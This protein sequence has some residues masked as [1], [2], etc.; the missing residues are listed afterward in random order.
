MHNHYRDLL[1]F[2]VKG[3]L[4]PEECAR[5]GRHLD[6]CAT[7]RE[8]VRQWR[9]VAAAVN[10]DAATWIP[11]L[12]PPPLKLPDENSQPHFS[13]DG[14]RHAGEQHNRSQAVERWPMLVKTVTQSRS[15]V[16]SW[17]RFT[18]LVAAVLFAVMLGGVIL[19]LV[20]ILFSVEGR[21]QPAGPPNHNKVITP[22]LIP[23]P[24]P[25]L[26]PTPMPPLPIG[27]DSVD[28]LTQSAVLGQ[29]YSTDV[30]W[31]PDGKTL[32]LGTSMDVLLYDTPRLTSQP[33]PL[34]ISIGEVTSVAFS[35]DGTQLAIGG[36]LGTALWD[37]V[38]GQ[39]R[40]LQR[41]DG[42]VLEVAFSPDGTRLA[43][44]REDGMARIWNTTTGQM[45]NGFGRGVLSIAF[46]PDGTTLAAGSDDETVQFWD[47]RT[48][49]QLNTFR[50]HTSEVLSV[51][52]SPDGTRLASGGDD[53]TVRLWDVD[54]GEMLAVLEGHT[55]D[56]AIVAF[57]PDGQILAS[58]SYDNSVRL[59]DVAAGE[60][61]ATLEGH[62]GD[63]RSLAFSPDGTI[64]VSTSSW[65][66]NTV[67][68]WDVASGEPLSVLDGCARGAHRGEVGEVAFSPD[69][70]RLALSCGDAGAAVWEVST[71]QSQPVLWQGNGGPVNSLALSPDGTMLAVGRGDGRTEPVTVQL[72]DVATGHEAAI[73][74][75][76]TDWVPGVAFSPDGTLLASGSWDR[77]VRL[78]NVTTRELVLVLSP[79]SDGVVAGESSIY[80]DDGDVTLHLDV[81]S[82][83]VSSVAFSPD[84]TKLAVGRGDPWVGPGSLQLYDAATGEL[85]AEFYAGATPPCCEMVSVTDLV[86]SPD[87]TMLAA[88]NGDGVA[89]VWDVATRK[90]LA[91]LDPDSGWLGSIAFSP[92]G[93]LLATGGAWS[94]CDYGEVCSPDE[95]EVRLWEVATGEQLAL[96]EGPEGGVRDVAFNPDGTLIA[97]VGGLED[98][99]VSL[100][101]TET[102]ETL[103]VLE[104]PYVS[105]VAFSTDGTLLVTGGNDGTVRLWR[106][107]GQ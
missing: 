17:Q 55:Q 8:D 10:A 48:G 67:R 20:A 53:N 2:Y 29:G 62:T 90:E 85:L 41:S 49:Q 88:A 25:T 24:T 31:S 11:H 19:A 35:P 92:D 3:L 27:P 69:G 79:L 105:C 63:V 107:V 7:C 76:H 45:W 6:Q 46:S 15:Q 86:F 106:V 61:R 91:A 87:G 65:E 44:R 78:W 43:S 102:G 71:W 51:A 57:S 12:L 70:T 22:T 42:G 16:S 18:R 75:G 59:W 1:P 95:G 33:R 103:A 93:S 56:V 28:R 14:N 80:D 40:V 84:G 21:G 74:E 47:M 23:S 104:S 39:E 36:R 60:L 26:T 68:L 64:L 50:G 89:R 77:T 9:Q 100:W 34:G 38:N 94:D 82:D 72:W 37:M 99:S 54:T 98:G 96:V 58:G 73:L 101:D 81:Y 52:F 97:F 30:A 5:L 66:D 32:A 13:D 4:S 83:G